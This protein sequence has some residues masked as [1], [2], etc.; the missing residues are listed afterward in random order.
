MLALMEVWGVLITTI[1]TL[2][3]VWLGSRLNNLGSEK[4]A[5]QEAKRV[6]FAKLL[7]LAHSEERYGFGEH[8]GMTDAEV[9]EFNRRLREW[10][11]KRR[12]I[13]GAA[14]EALF[15]SKSEALR[16]RLRGFINTDDPDHTLRGI[17]DLLQAELEV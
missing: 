4:L 1:A 6:T 15:L 13:K 12:E 16:T 2:V 9:V 10:R 14:S 11:E 5:M 7:S 3:G 8:R 17:E